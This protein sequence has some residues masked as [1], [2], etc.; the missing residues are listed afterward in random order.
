MRRAWAWSVTLGWSSIIKA[1]SRRPRRL[2]LHLFETENWKIVVLA[3]DRFGFETLH[4]SDKDM[5]ARCLDLGG[6]CWRR[7]ITQ[8]FAV[9]FKLPS[10]LSGLH[11][12]AYLYACTDLQPMP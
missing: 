1:R 12:D 5:H 10:Y 2:R 4:G 8:L 3:L 11:M 6:S 7:Q 9:E